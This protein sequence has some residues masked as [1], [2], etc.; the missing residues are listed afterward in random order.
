MFGWVWKG[1]EGEMEEVHVAVGNEASR[2]SEFPEFGHLLVE[3][4]RCKGARHKVYLLRAFPDCS[5]NRIDPA[6][7]TNGLAT[8]A[9]FAFSPSD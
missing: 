4:V 2:R 6:T 9:S 1:E 7:L 3:D 8:L 5:R